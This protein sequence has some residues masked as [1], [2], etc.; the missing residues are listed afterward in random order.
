[1]V[2]RKRL[3]FWLGMRT[4]RELRRTRERNDWMWDLVK[5]HSM[6]FFPYD[7]RIKKNI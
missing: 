6:C 3:E 7:F 5:G 1:M 4:R 2:E